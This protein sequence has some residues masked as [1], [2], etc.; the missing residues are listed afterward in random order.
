M[1]VADKMQFEQVKT[2]LQKSRSQISDLQ[3]QA[4][5]QK[6]VNKPS[7]DPLAATR[8]LASKVDLQGNRQFSKSMAYARSFMEFT[9][10][11]LGELSEVL[12]RAK[13]LAI[14]Q[15]TDAG[16]NPE[17]RRAVATELEQLSHQMVAIGNRKLG[18][19]FI[20]GGF[21]T[22]NTPF[23]D[24]GRYGGD[25]GEMMIHVDKETFLPMNVPGGRVFLGEGITADGMVKS[26][27]SQA[28]TIEEMEE[29]R[30]AQNP[31]SP[32]TEVRGPASQQATP[33]PEP[34]PPVRGG[35]NL[36]QLMSSLNV[37]LTTNDKEGV[38][39]TL[40][41]LDQALDQ[42]VLTRAQVGSRSTVLDNLNQTVEKQKVENKAAISSFED[43]DV[44]TTVT[45][46]SKA[47]STLQATLE[48]SGK[49]IQPSLM[50]FIR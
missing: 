38:Q 32:P 30:R 6:R 28:K 47:Q 43:A 7:D 8:V 13:E 35:I 40:E 24:Q 16:A 17:S 18:D 46:L 14:G 5:T 20:F 36:F 9:D 25:N 39:D 26:F 21:H 29:Q 31:P 49:L 33:A 10:Q 50:T 42:V 41:A 1:R 11:S 15:S 4:A 19:R 27:P 23:D 37:A 48:S 12:V 3:N 22:Q 45:D 44:F 34:E 2:N